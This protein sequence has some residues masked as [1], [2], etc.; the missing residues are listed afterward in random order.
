MILR[1]VLVQVLCQLK[2]VS[3]LRASLSASCHDSDRDVLIRLNAGGDP[4]SDDSDQYH[5]VTMT[6]PGLPLYCRSLT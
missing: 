3:E 6:Q 1:L 4:G 2:A 5:D